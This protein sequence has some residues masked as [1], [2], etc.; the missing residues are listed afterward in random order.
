MEK[1]GCLLNRKDKKSLTAGVFWR[2]DGTEE[3]KMRQKAARGQTYLLMTN[4]LGHRRSDGLGMLIRM[5]RIATSRLDG[6]NN[7]WMMGVVVMAVVSH[8]KE[9]NAAGLWMGLLFG[10]ANKKLG[11]LS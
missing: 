4:P 1:S 5:L 2:R 11:S 3:H 7:V 9:A 6:I 10:A 8:G